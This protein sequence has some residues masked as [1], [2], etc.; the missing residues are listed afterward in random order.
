MMEYR[1][2]ADPAYPEVEASKYTDV[3]KSICVT[4]KKLK[5]GVGG[6]LVSNPIQLDGLR[7]CYPECEIVRADD[8]MVALR[9]IKSENELKG[10]AELIELCRNGSRQGFHSEAEGYK[11]FPEKI[12]WACCHDD[13]AF[14]LLY[15][16]TYSNNKNTKPTKPPGLIL[17]LEPRRLLLGSYNPQDLGW[18]FFE[19]KSGT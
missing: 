18:V 12:R 15:T 8:I 6:Y 11:Y 2:S 19:K 17:T 3:F 7:E 4:G 14:Y 9:S 13:E 16:C 5:I 10:D 1:E